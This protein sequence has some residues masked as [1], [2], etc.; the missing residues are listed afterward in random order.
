MGDQVNAAA[1]AELVAHGCESCRGGIFREGCLLINNSQTNK[2][3]FRL[4]SLVSSLPL[5]GRRLRQGGSKPNYTY[6]RDAE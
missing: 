5:T 1:L 3:A 4:L 6:P 2:I